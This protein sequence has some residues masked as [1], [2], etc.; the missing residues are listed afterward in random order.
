MTLT[1]TPEQ[2]A[3]IA[4]FGE[5]HNTAIQ[6]RAGAGKTS[7][8]KL[9]AGTTPK[10]GAY[11]AFNRAIVDDAKRSMPGNVTASTAH[12]LAFR[13]VGKRYQHRLNSRRMRSTDIARK[14]RVDHFVI[15]YGTQSK[16]M[17]PGYLGGLAMRA[18]TIFCQTADTEPGL[19]H[20]PYIDGIDL[21][22]E[23]GRRTFGN[24]R[25][26]AA[27]VLPAVRRAWEDLQRLD[28]E[29]PFTH[30]HYLKLW[31]LDDP[32]I[33][34]DFILF[35]EAQDASPVMLAAVTAQRDAQLVFVGDSEQ[36]IYEFTGAVNALDNVPS[37]HTAYLTQSFRFGDAIAEQANAVLA[38]LGAS[39]PVS[40]TPSIASA[41]VPVAE[42]DAVL[43]RTNAAAVQTVLEAQRVGQR[44]HLVGGGDE[45]VRFAKAAKELMDRGDT[46]HP[47]LACFESWKEVQDYVEHDEQGGELKLLVSLVD[48][49]GAEVIE[50]ALGRMPAEDK[51]SLVVSTAHKSK[52]REW[53]SVQL[54]GDFPDPKEGRDPST[55]ELRLLYVAVT[56]ARYELDVSGVALLTDQDDAGDGEEPPM[57]L[58]PMDDS[59]LDAKALT[60]KY[61]TRG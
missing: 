31:Q 55:A 33:P 26:V 32:V 11:V 35:D 7:T 60:M 8:L 46:W 27:H 30:G 37:D 3:A 39:P 38:R 50:S 54:A 59:A 24:N 57:P 52:G 17:Q 40:G 18:V 16:V 45:V 41:V 51:A 29:L 56:R 12:S 44:P 48:S 14:L 47:D 19:Q 21:P 10:R 25:E 22:T 13:T 15:K 9:L 28:G 34:A 53:G 5:G 6:A 58:P 2:E 4:L 36:A 1:P 49:F 20:I 61:G 23:D 42:P 43:C